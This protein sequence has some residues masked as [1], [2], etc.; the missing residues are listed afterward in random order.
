MADSVRLTVL[1]E[2][3]TVSLRS[4]RL[5]DDGVR[6]H[7]RGGCR[8]HAHSPG[9]DAAPCRKTLRSLRSL[10]DVV[11]NGANGD[12][13]LRPPHGPGRGPDR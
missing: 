8:L 11:D 2:G 7:H 10:A 3:P 5:V 4:L 6:Q 13:R 12:G 1:A 9:C